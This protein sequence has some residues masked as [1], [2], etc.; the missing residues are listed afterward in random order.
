MDVVKHAHAHAAHALEVRV[1]APLEEHLV[2]HEVG[3]VIDN[4]AATVHSAGFA[5]AQVQVQIIA[6]A[7]SVVGTTLEVVILV[8]DDLQAKRNHK[9][10]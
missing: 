6:V 5:A 4:A 2:P 8:E 1:L 10:P 9:H 7:A 3:A